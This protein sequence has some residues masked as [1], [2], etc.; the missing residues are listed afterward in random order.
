MA[1]RAVTNCLCSLDVRDARSQAVHKEAAARMQSEEEAMQKYDR[2][3]Q[4]HIVQ[5]TGIQQL[6]AQ[7]E[8]VRS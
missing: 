7:L 3:M 1:S 5:H 6:Q 2:M 8:Q 4:R